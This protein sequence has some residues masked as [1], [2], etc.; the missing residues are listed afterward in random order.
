MNYHAID[1]GKR[2]MVLHDGSRK[3]VLTVNSVICIGANWM[4]EQTHDSPEKATDTSIISEGKPRRLY[5]WLILC[6]DSKSRIKAC[7]MSTY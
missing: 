1:Y 6:N 5:S 7:F 2:C 3:P 4:H